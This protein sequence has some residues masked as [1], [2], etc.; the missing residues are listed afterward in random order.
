[1]PFFGGGGDYKI[2][3]TN[4]KGGND[5]LAVITGDYNM[6]LG[7]G[8]LQS[9]STSNN[10]IAIGQNSLN[11]LVAAFVDDSSDNVSIGAY[12]A[13]TATSVFESVIIGSQSLNLITNESIYTSVVIGHSTNAAGGGNVVI[14]AYAGANFG[15]DNI[16][17]GA[18]AGQ[19]L[20][21]TANNNIIIQ[22]S[23][24]GLPSDNHNIVIGNST[25][26]YIE[27]GGQVISGPF[28]AEFPQAIVGDP[29]TEGNGINVG[30]VTYNADFKVSD[31]AATNIAHSIL[32]RH[33]TTLPSIFLA[34]R[35]NSDTSA[36]LPVTIGMDL[37]SHYT[38]GWVGTFYQIFS[39]IT[40]SVDNTG[41][42]SD[43][44]SPGK[45][46]FATTPDAAIFPVERMRINNAGALGFAGAN[47]GAAGEVLTSNGSAAPPSFQA[48][49]GGGLTLATMQN[50]SGGSVTFG[51]IPAGVKQINIM[52]TAVSSTGANNFHI[53]IGGS[54]GIETTGYRCTRAFI[55][56]GPTTGV[57]SDTGA[58][59]NGF[60]IVNSNAANLFS[61]CI[62]LTLMD[63]ATNLWVASGLI[64][65]SP[66]ANA[67][68][69]IT[70]G[71]KAIA[72]T[73]TQ[74]LIKTTGAD[75]FDGGSFNISY[76]S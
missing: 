66:L 10:N 28:G 29:G 39:S 54:G 15:N 55:L 9:S 30:G 45:L 31:I 49:A 32:H 44:S 43:T 65:G 69:S 51:S 18:G 42:V 38:A 20:A 33:S 8:A 75:T 3:G 1:M 12:A 46:V 35:S 72:S 60:N 6:A 4:I 5:A 48:A 74:L 26:T 22:D 62:Q 73:L 7:N 47:F 34:A 57:S 56:T 53:Q 67:I 21:A 27:I 58:N 52:W 17:I 16:C 71:S 64:G 37:F 2:V 40:H 63:S 19:S 76:S 14:G 36:H 70:S 24:S 68:M 11:L 61:G 50:A 25:H 23:G 13:D 41:T 59:D